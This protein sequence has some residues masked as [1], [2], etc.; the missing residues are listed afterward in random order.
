MTETQQNQ[1]SSAA[2]DYYFMLSML[3]KHAALLIMSGVLCGALLFGYARFFVQARYEASALFFVNSSSFN[4][5]TAISVTSDADTGKVGNYLQILKSRSTLEEIIEIA[6]V[7]IGYKDLREMI[8]AEALVNTDMIQVTVNANNPETARVLANTIADVLP[9]KVSQIAASTSLEIVDYA[10]T[11]ENRVSPN[12]IVFAAYGF[13]GGF[14]LCMLAILAVAFFDNVIREADYVEQSYQLPVMAEIPDL[15]IKSG[16]RYGYGYGYGS[17]RTGVREKRTTK[18]S[19]GESGKD[20]SDA[21]GKGR[22]ARQTRAAKKSQQMLFDN[23]SFVA[24]EAYKRLRTNLFFALPEKPCR[25]LGVTSSVRGE[26]KSTTAVNLAFSFAQAGKRVLLIDADMRLPSVDVKMDIKR[27]P[28]LSN[29]L[30]GMNT[31]KECLRRSDHY[32]NWIVLP[33]GDVPPNPLE[34]LGSERMHALLERYAEVFDYII[35]DLPP[36]NI[37]ADA[38]VASKWTDGLITIVREGYTDRNALKA[39][40]NQVRR[41]DVKMLGFVM[42]FVSVGSPAYKSYGKYGKRYGYGYD[43]KDERVFEGSDA[44]RKNWEFLDAIEND[45]EREPLSG[46]NEE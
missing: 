38:L 5:N 25:I 40:M 9:E 42:T 26:G 35:L 41:L 10:E 17:A 33:A 37:V 44:E 29:L 21:Q 16:G 19:T 28:G 45:L 11:P 6:G 43:K 13:V 15:D 18:S 20:T 27:T 7:D 36:V 46:E 39:N 22:S 1:Q 24:T 14:L 23:M 2:I 34:L 30:V 12:Y 31:E 32:E 4:I 3:W 8:T